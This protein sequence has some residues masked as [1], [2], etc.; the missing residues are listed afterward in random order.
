MA[1]K[2]HAKMG[3]SAV[4]GEIRKHYCPVCPEEEGK[5]VPANPVMLMPGRRIVFSCKAGHET[6]KGQTILR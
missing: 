5:L 4:A 1:G 3:H 6:G 2:K